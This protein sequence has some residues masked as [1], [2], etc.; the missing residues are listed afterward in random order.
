MARINNVSQNRRYARWRP[1][2]AAASRAVR[3]GLI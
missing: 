1:R 3:N 2:L